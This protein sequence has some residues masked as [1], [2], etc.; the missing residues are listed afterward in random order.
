V[1]LVSV[2]LLLWPAIDV[3][4]AK[5]ETD[6]ETIRYLKSLNLEDLAG[7][8]VTSV[9]KKTEKLSDAAAAVFV[10]TEEDIR[11]SGATNIPEALRMVPGVQVAHI[12]ANKWAVTSRGF[13]GSF[14]NKLLVLIDGR[15]VYSPLWSGV[16][17]NIQDTMLEDIER[18]EVI[19]GPGASLWGANA[20]NGIISII[21]KKVK[22]TQG[23]LIS[24]GIGTEER[25]F[26][27][28][29]YGLQSSERS[30][31]RLYTKY[32]NRDAGAQPD[33]SDGN[34][35]W[36]GIRGGFR[37]DWES[38][39]SNEITLQ[40]DLYSQKA[41]VTY[42]FA[43]LNPP[44]YVDT[45]L[46][47][48]DQSGGNLL[49]RWEH[50]SSGS[51]HIALQIYYDHTRAKD[52][53]IDEVRDTFD[54]DFQ[55]RIESIPRNEVIWGLGYR[56]TRDETV[57]LRNTRFDPKDRTLN[58]YS[59][60]IQDRI[61]IV[62]DRFWL[63]LGS[64]FEHNDYTGWEVQPTGRFLWKPR[65]KHSLWGAVSRAVRT[66]SR[67]ERDVQFDLTTIPPGSPENPGPL[68]VLVRV[69]GSDSFESEEVVAFE[70]GYRF[71]V[72]D[73]MLWDIAAFYNSYDKINA[74]ISSGPTPA[75]PPPY[76]LATETLANEE[77]L[78]SRG[79]EVAID[80]IPTDWWKVDL[81]YTYLRLNQDSGNNDISG[82]S[83][84][85]QLSLRST[86]DLLRY[87]EFDLWIR[88]VDELPRLN[89]E[90]YFTFDVRLGWKPLTNLEVALVGQNLANEQQLEFVDQFLPA[91]STE[92]ERS[93]YTKVA[94]MF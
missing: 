34:D 42:D 64:K 91:R 16:F 29:R 30:H 49:T 62:A 78:D 47:D 69:N 27:H 43:S 39:T 10:I 55:H 37:F 84:R 92:V 88:Y 17:W 63:T 70:L 57:D 18:I 77:K 93:V 72:N 83:P 13:N 67:A 76:L 44:N 21:T 79:I 94:W 60:F 40:G 15:T 7:L 65:E 38:K 41:G 26:A 14:A 85:N 5:S 36:S 53:L 9:S 6:K 12:D 90:D 50:T 19:R 45:V 51:S 74:S 66:P 3:A 31:L 22:D 86:M 24:G 73:R 56:I 71:L 61:A 52:Q 28:A 23:G 81:A 80:L 35:D 20:V 87:F 68:P 46:E 1:V 82:S 75:G 54:I 2:A 58:L 11:R 32:F 59:G 8:E 25:F 89:V 4:D 33:G 48:S